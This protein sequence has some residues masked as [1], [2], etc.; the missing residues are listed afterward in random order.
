MGRGAPATD[1]RAA[2]GTQAAPGSAP[3]RAAL[4]AV[5]EVTASLIVLVVF[6]G[7]ALLTF[8]GTLTGHIEW[9]RR[10]P[11][12]STQVRAAL[13]GARRGLESAHVRAGVKADSARLRRELERELSALDRR[14]GEP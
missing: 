9:E 7:L 1:G 12:V 3:R 14:E 2:G 10:E 4:G 6:A 11:P 5:V 13:H 8:I